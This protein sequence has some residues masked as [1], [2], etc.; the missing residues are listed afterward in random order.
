MLLMEQ[1][2]GDTFEAII[3]AVWR[4]GF[5]VELIDYLLRLCSGG[6]HPDDYYRSIS[7][8]TR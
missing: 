2:L 6:R 4:D 1:H 8:P 7:H 3:I 5:V